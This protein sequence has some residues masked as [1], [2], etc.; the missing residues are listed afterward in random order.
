MSWSLLATSIEQSKSRKSGDD[1]DVDID[2]VDIDVDID[3]NDDLT[4]GISQHKSP[5]SLGRL[6]SP[7]S[8]PETL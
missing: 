5:N 3:N 7:E 4:E 1:V 2:D 6:L 8:S